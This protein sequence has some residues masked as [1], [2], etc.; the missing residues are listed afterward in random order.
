[1]KKVLMIFGLMAYNLFSFGQTSFNYE[2][3]G[4]V[5]GLGKDTLTLMVTNARSGKPSDK[6]MIPAFDDTFIF[7]GISNQVEMAY[8]YNEKN[9]RIGDLTLFLDEGII[10]V[11]G[12]LSNFSR[13]QVYGTKANDD[14]LVM[15]QQES[16]YYDEITSM[17]A[18]LKARTDTGASFYK[19]AIAKI[20]AL[21]DSAMKSKERFAEKNPGSYVSGI[22][23]YVLSDRIP[24]ERLDKLYTDLDPKV[25]QMGLISKLADKIEGK[26][27][28]LVGKTASDFSI[29]DINGK[30]VKL[31]DFKGKYVLLDFWASWCVPCREENPYLK[32]AYAKYKDKGF[33]IIG[34]SV[35]EN[36]ERWKKA[37][38]DDNLPWIHVSDL[39]RENFIAG[40]YGVQPIP[41]NFLVSPDGKIIAKA[42][43]GSQIEDVLSKYIGMGK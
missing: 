21:Q 30:P 2:I 35:D 23:L 27:R 39:K 37:I 17:R 25:K 13:S 18:D 10:Q 32:T 5:K 4:M 1:M 20:S 19:S 3:R 40:L 22:N 31:S 29:Q 15:R 42:I 26:R 38:A 28:S 34:V 43:R 33:E 16:V 11:K 6:Y 12:D 14:M 7:K 24:F 8:L 9:R 41:D 36:G